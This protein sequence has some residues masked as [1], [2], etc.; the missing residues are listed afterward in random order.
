M[1]YNLKVTTSKPED[2]KEIQFP[3]RITLNLNC[4]S[5]KDEDKTQLPRT[6]GLKQM[7][8]HYPIFP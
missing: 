6:I 5:F 7:L 8:A 3:N 2:L 1:Y 4:S